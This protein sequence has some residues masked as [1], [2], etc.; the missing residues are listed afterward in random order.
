MM[1]LML[2]AFV[3]ASIAASPALASE[4]KKKSAE[5][6]QKAPEGASCKVPAVGR[7]ASCAISCQPGETATCAPGVAVSDVCH[8][9][10]SCKCSK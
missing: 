4:K 8:T 3:A 10:P 2:A 7:C 1:K 9:Q 6:K 5:T